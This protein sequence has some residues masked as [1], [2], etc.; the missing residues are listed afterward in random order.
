MN[1]SGESVN[2]MAQFGFENDIHSILKLDVP[3]TNAP[4]ARWQRMASS[5]C[6]SAQTAL[7]P[8]KPATASLSLSKT[9]SKTPGN[10]FKQLETQ[11]SS[12]VE[13]IFPYN[14]FS[15]LIK[16]KIKNQHRLK[17]GVTDTFQ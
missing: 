17:C 16:A 15:S 14:H 8:G 4:T 13:I 6:K 2:N 12:G 7:S 9:P 11:Q 3:I 10:V 1:R 5:S